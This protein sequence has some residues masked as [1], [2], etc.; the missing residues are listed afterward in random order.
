MNTPPL[1]RHT[2]LQPFSRDHYTGLVQAQHLLRASDENAS[3]LRQALMD[4][5]RAWKCEIEEHFTNEEVL[6]SALMTAAQ[7]KRLRND[8]DLLRAFAGQAAQWQPD[9]DPGAGWVQEL[10]QL[11]NDHIR[12]E[13]RKLFPAIERAC[14]QDQLTALERHTAELEGRR[15]RAAC[16]RPQHPETIDQTESEK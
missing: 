15:P 1:K 13:E 10:G 16:L 11:L 6:L 2:A 9:V 14:T 4:F 8:H 3:G 5:T 12:W 7:L